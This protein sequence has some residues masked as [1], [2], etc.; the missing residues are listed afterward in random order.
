MPAIFAVFHAMFLNISGPVD[1]LQVLALLRHYSI[2]KSLE[3][4]LL[5]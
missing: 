2:E 1:V 3:A 5:F 4:T